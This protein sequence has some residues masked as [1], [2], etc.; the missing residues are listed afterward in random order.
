MFLYIYIYLTHKYIYIYLLI[1]LMLA[2]C[3]DREREREIVP[4]AESSLRS[5]HVLMSFLPGLCLKCPSVKM[6][7]I[8]CVC[9]CVGFFLMFIVGS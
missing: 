2:S 7:N 3:T 6:A 4:V 1:Q 8:R 5:S 9:V